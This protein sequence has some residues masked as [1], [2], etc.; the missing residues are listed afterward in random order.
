MPEISL[1]SGDLPR[2]AQFFW[3]IAGLVGVVGL[4][5]FGWNLADEP[6]FAD[7]SAYFSQAYFAD[8]FL[9]GARN[10]TAWVEYPAYDLPPLPKYLMGWALRASGHKYPG[11]DTWLVWYR[12][13]SSRFD[14]P[15]ALTAARVPS[16]VLGALG[17][18]AVYALGT[19]AY[20]QRAGLLAALLLMFD[21][22]YRTHARRAMSDADTEAFVLLALAVALWTLRRMLARKSGPLTWLSSTLVGV[23]SGLAVLCKLSGALALI[24]V[25]AWAAFV[26]V[27]A[28]TP[29]RTRLAIAEQLVRAGLV[30]LGVFIALN[31]FLT[32][33]PRWA[34]GPGARVAAMTVPERMKLLVTLR[35]SVSHDQ[36]IQFEHNALRRPAEK[37]AAVAVQGYGRFGLLGPRR[38]DSRIRF[39]WGQDRGALLW[40]PLVFAGGVVLFAR[41]RAQRAFGEPP[42]AWAVLIQAI[43]T[44][45]VVTL[46]I[47]MAWDRY[48]LALQSGSALLGAAALVAVFDAVWQ[49]TAHRHR[50][51]AETLS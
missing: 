51:L 16:V 48:Y 41:G 5:V 21:P 30:A 28:G 36:Q 37:V 20:D 38:D 25:G 17:C 8:L 13:T 4:V 34:P 10:D 49:R 39:E 50:R 9:V 43:V 46:Y 24:V 3:P 26:W 19:L 27:L 23:F 44:L 32:A 40:L 15:G 18:V 14:A 33:A 11:R 29:F 2:S 12:N 1:N 31:P 42:A 45:L 7:E 47:P 22:L 35:R 6:H